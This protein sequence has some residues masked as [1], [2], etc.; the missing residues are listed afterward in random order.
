MHLVA[1]SSIEDTDWIVTL[2]DESPSG[3]TRILTRGCLRASH[4]ELDEEK[5]RPGRPWHPHTRSVPLTPNQEE[6]FEIEIVPTGNLFQPGH[7]IRL[8]IASCAS[9]V[10]RVAYLDTLPIRAENTVIEGGGG[11]YLLASVI[12]R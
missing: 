1:R 7:R 9:A 6:V 10:D 11:S 2:L 8:E 5:S 4:R 3:E 12:P